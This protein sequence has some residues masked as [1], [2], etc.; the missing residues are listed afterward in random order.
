MWRLG[1]RLVQVDPDAFAAVVVIAAPGR[2][3]HF[4]DAHSAPAAVAGFGEL[5]HTQLVIQGAEQHGQL[6]LVEMNKRIASNLTNIITTLEA[7]GDV[8]G[9]EGLFDGGK[10]LF[11]G[12]D[13][14]R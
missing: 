9:D 12:G 8:D 5:A 1:G 11:D 13:H 2:A 6:R 4:D 3:E 7:D 10:G 14:A